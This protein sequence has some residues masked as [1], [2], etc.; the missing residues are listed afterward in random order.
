M[1]AAATRATAR[2]SLEAWQ[3]SVGE[4]LAAAWGGSYNAR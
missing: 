3:D 1:A 4:L 2:Y